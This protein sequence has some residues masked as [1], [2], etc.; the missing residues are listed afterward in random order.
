MPSY[1]DFVAVFGIHDHIREPRFSGFRDQTLLTKPSKLR[2]DSLGRSGRQFQLCW[3]LK[4]PGRWSEEG[5][6]QPGPEKWSIRQGAFHHQFDVEHG[7]TLWIVTKPG[8]DIKERIQDVTGKSGN[9]EDRK[10]ST[11]RECLK[12]T[13]AIH[14]LIGHWATE[15]WRQYFQWLEDKIEDEVKYEQ[16]HSKRPQLTCSQFQTFLLVYGA[17]GPGKESQIYSSS[18][19][20]KAQE[21]DEQTNEATMALQGNADVLT[22]VK[23]FYKTLSENDDFP[24]GQSCSSDI[25]AFLRQMESFVYDSKMQIARGKL[26]GKIVAARKT[27]TFF[28]TDVVKYQDQG[29]NSTTSNSAT[30]DTSYSAIAMDRGLSDSNALLHNL[31]ACPIQASPRLGVAHRPGGGRAGRMDTLCVS[32]QYDHENNLLEFKTRLSECTRTAVCGRSFVLLEKFQQWLRGDATS[33][34][35]HLSL[36][37]NAAYRHRAAPGLPIPDHIF[38]ASTSC[39]LL[40]FCI[41][42]TIG[43]GELIHVFVEERK[44]DSQLPLPPDDVAEILRPHGASHLASAFAEQQHRF[45]PATF[46]HRMPAKW[47]KDSVIPIC[48]K[49]PI[50][51]GGTA[52]LWLIDV[53]E[54]FVGEG[55][56]KESSRSRF[57]VNARTN[58]APDWRY[59]FALKTFTSVDQKVFENERNAFECLKDHKGMVKYL[60]WFKSVECKHGGGG[61]TMGMVACPDMGKA[62]C[63]DH[64]TTCNILLEFAD[65]DLG[66]YFQNRLPPALS[67]EVE[68]FWKALFAIADA[69]KDIHNFK[70]NRGEE[71][72][73][74]YGW[75]TDIKPDNIL[76]VED[77]GTGICKF[78]LADP[79]FAQ[80]E[81]KIRGTI[82][83]KK[84]L[85]G[86][87]KTYGPPEY[88]GGSKLPVSQA[89]DIWSLGCVLS[90][91]ATWAILGFTGVLQFNELRRRTIQRLHHSRQDHDIGDGDP[92]GDQFHDGH[93]LLGVV[94]E[95]HQYL[96]GRIRKCDA[97]SIQVL[98]LID[99]K[100]LITDPRMRIKA[101]DLCLRLHKIID[102]GSVETTD[103]VPLEIQRNL[104]EIDA[105]VALRLESM[106]RSKATEEEAVNGMSRDGRKSTA[107]DLMLKTTH[108]QSI[109]P[110]GNGPNQHERPFPVLDTQVEASSESLPQTPQ[111]NRMIRREGRTETGLSRGTPTRTKVPKRSSRH[112]PQDV[113]QAREAVEDRDKGSHKRWPRLWKHAQSKKDEVLANYFD[114]RDIIFLVDNA[115]T[116]RADWYRATYLLE[117]MVMKAFAQDP[118][119][120]DLNFTTGTVKI[121]QEEKSSVFV[122]KMKQGYPKSGVGTNMVESLGKIFNQYLNRLRL[123]RGQTRDVTLIVLTDGLW[124]GTS[125]KEDVKEKIVDFLKSLDRLNHSMKHRPFSIEFVRFGC[126]HDAKTRL[127]DLDNFLRQRNVGAGSQSA[128]DTYKDMIDTEHA[129]GD[130]NKMLL[131]SFVE[132]YDEDEE[133]DDDLDSDPFNLGDAT[134]GAY[135]SG[136][137]S[138]PASYAAKCSCINLDTVMTK[139]E[140]SEADTLRSKP[141]IVRNASTSPL[142]RLPPE[143]RNQI[144][145]E[146]LGRR[147]IHLEY[148]CEPDDDELTWKHQVCEDDAPEDQPGEKCTFT[149]KNGIHLVYWCRPHYRCNRRYPELLVALP[150]DSD[151]YEKMHLTL[152]RSCRQIYVEANQVLWSTNTFSFTAP[153]SFQHFTQT[154]TGH[155]KRLI[156]T[157][158]L[159]MEWTPKRDIVPWIRALTMTV[160]RSFTGL[161]ALRLQII[162]D[163]EAGV[164]RRVAKEEPE[165]PQGTFWC[166]GLQ[167]LSVL[168]LARVEVAVRGTELAKYQFGLE[169]WTERDRKELGDRV[170]AMLLNP[171]GAEAYAEYQERQKEISRSLNRRV[172]WEPI[173]PAD[174][175]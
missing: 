23:D 2:V 85:W 5:T 21:I 160:V 44:R 119:G 147:L 28:S 64:H 155:Q 88:P 62:A 8:L 73:E 30:P 70:E 92:E 133:D 14:L 106:R 166:D 161:R 162:H 36:Q 43:R 94:T 113:F 32:T 24:L 127:K 81:P 143:I 58:K 41:L 54:E 153:V 37:L 87:T 93:Q 110:P 51:E 18:N 65:M 46:E 96:R 1:L 68:E 75:H 152:L 111:R 104:K 103:N 69:V 52:H 163:M 95:W 53:P 72:R 77:T 45:C 57:N 116:M 17:R 120:M 15:K 171:K 136:W 105:V 79:G 137:T 47:P 40:I 132:A 170:Q 140:N 145:T 102:E 107:M 56:R 11:P 34:N 141:S 131:G 122:S 35:T 142:L 100:M 112:A 108:R 66:V 154:R 126:D 42:Q 74:Y 10:F 50:N 89:I 22:S 157:L 139:R 135:D 123:T 60:G 148:D 25:G 172:T 124:S 98:E 83:P 27:I 71:V 82:V 31:L 76:N 164:Y 125:R 63:P 59:E 86:G 134:P 101:D 156:R 61:R 3:N 90:L 9:E 16:V 49:T 20:Q 48:N 19:L 7:T 55:L 4:S 159:E 130:V 173:S 118:D 84:Q 175:T 165:F 33:T 6:L 168:P 115:E 67:K 149:G 12:S 38:E 158:R 26:L 109:L 129:S 117:T 167:K 39:C 97:I 121:E 78:K 29:G 169:Q 128:A 138:P 151:E 80:F 99:D 13:F 174:S 144:W 91:A 150:L 114:Q 146:V